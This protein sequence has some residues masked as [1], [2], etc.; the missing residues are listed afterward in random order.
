M[1]SGDLN[2]T[3]ISDLK[4]TVKNFSITS[5]TM[6]S[7]SNVGGSQWSY[8]DS[9]TYWNYYETIPELASAVEMLAI[10]SVGKGYTTDAR[11]QATLDNIRGMGNESFE[12]ICFNL[13]VQKKIFG[14]AFAHI[15]RNDKG[16]IINLIPLWAG[17]IITHFDE[18][19]LIDFYEY[20]REG[21]DSKRIETHEMLHLVNDRV[22]NSM[23]GKSI[24]KTVK[25][26]IDARNEL[27]NDWRRI[28]HR[29]TVRVMYIEADNTT[30][31]TNVKTQYATAIEKGE[32]LIIPAKKGEAEFEELTLPPHAAFLETIKYYEGFFY[33]AC[34][35]PRSIAAPENNTEAGGKVGY[36][37]FEPIYTWE[38]K[39][40][41][42]DLLNQ[43]GIQVEF[44]RP[45]S[46]SGMLQ[47]SE[48]K[49]TG[50]TGMQ[51]NELTPS[52][53]RNE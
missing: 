50:Q 14:D 12:E 13:I 15:V 24:I 11:T 45:P 21:A 39:P 16:T 53:V 34:R 2:Q 20:K 32:L 8:S 38:Q 22:G 5:Q 51:P 10:Y 37:G 25:W 46:L 9:G 4:G 31:L 27:M 36:L 1:P 49:N 48:N 35:I 43:V 29:A 6:D 33:Q 17:D 44:N 23:H 28:C 7:P 26:V 42:K 41:E 18:K 30:K 47:Q 3:Q 40:F 19:G 52:M